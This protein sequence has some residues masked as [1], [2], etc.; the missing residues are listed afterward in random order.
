MKNLEIH[1]KNSQSPDVYMDAVSGAGG[2]EGSCYAQDVFELFDKIH[3][4]LA[5][6][7]TLGKPFTMVVNVDYYNTAASKCFSQLFEQIENINRASNEA[8]TVTI[9]TAPET[10]DEDR[11]SW[12]E[13]IPEFPTATFLIA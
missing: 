7:A 4:W 11:E 2:I 6:Y 12:L 13:H 9:L 8:W 10:H 1:K 3:H 5:D